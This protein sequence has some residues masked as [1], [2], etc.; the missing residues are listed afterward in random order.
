MTAPTI[1]RNKMIIVHGN[2]PAE[3]GVE[4]EVVEGGV[5][6]GR[7]VDAFEG[8]PLINMMVVGKFPLMLRFGADEVMVLG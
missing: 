5:V 4:A 1:N 8:V 2:F 3:G 7:V 6:E